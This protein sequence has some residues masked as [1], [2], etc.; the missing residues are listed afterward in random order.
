M[1]K[2][3]PKGM[4]TANKQV[5]TSPQRQQ[6]DLMAAGNNVIVLYLIYSETVLLK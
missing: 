5:A 4:D 3:Q 2:Q 1:T 6:C